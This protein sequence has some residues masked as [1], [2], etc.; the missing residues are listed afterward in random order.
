MNSP[1]LQQLKTELTSQNQ[2][3]SQAVRQLSKLMNALDQR[4]NL[5]MSTI[6]NGLIFWELRQVMRIEKWKETHASD[7]P[8]WIETIGEIDAYCS[9]ATFTYNHPDYIFPKISSQSFH[10]RAEALGHPLMNR[11]KCCLLYTS[12]AADD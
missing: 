11:N 2:T 9:L 6:L 12:D 3:A 8:R 10:L 4:S 5:L 1:V 7:L